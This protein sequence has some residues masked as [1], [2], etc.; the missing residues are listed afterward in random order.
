SEVVR[1]TVHNTG[2]RSITYRLRC[3]GPLQRRTEV[4]GWSY[5]AFFCNLP[6]I[7]PV[8]IRPGGR[9]T[10]DVGIFQPP[11]EYRVVAELFD[12]GVELTL[13]MRASEP[14]EIQPR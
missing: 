2:A 10:F 1:A 8:E 6:Y 4:G 12:G 13:A 9:L 3:G 7:P 14:F 5:I 11:G